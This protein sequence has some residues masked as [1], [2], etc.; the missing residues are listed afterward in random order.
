MLLFFSREENTSLGLCFCAFLRE[1][2]HNCLFFPFLFPAA[3][4][5]SRYDAVS[6]GRISAISREDGG[7]SA[8]AHRASYIC[9]LHTLE[10]TK[11]MKSHKNREDNKKKEYPKTGSSDA[12]R[13]R[14]GP[15]LKDIPDAPPL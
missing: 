8:A 14:P 3:V 12:Q 2:Y 6:S 11:R 5:H 1:E 4:I 10:N 9:T 15:I 13:C 7:L